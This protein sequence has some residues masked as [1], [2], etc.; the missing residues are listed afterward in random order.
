MDRPDH[1][2]PPALGEGHGAEQALRRVIASSPGDIQAHVDLASLLTRVGRVGE[3]IDLLDQALIRLPAAVWPLSVK[4][5]VLESD[6][7]HGD[8]L[9]VHRALLARAPRAALP[10]TN[11]GRALAAAGEVPAAISAYRKSLDLEPRQGLAWWGLANLRTVRLDPE[12]VAR[13]ERALPDVTEGLNRTQLHYALGKAL[14]DQQRFG[15]SFEHYEAGNR[16]RGRFTAYSAGAL[17]EAVQQIQTIF[18]PAFLAAREGQGC[19]APG[20][21]FIVGMP[22]SGS[23]LVEQILTSHPLVEG[24]GELAELGEVVAVGESLDRID[25]ASAVALG[26]RYMAAVQRHRRTT[27]PFFT[28]KMPANW[29]HVGLIRLML[30]N[31]KII[32][33]RREPMA[34]CFSSFTTYFNRQTSFPASLADLGLYYRDYVRTMDHVDRVTPVHRVSYERLVEDLEGE[35][36][37]LLDHLGLPFAAACLRFHENPRAVQTPSAQQ[38]RRP[39]NRE[40]LDRWRNYEPWLA[41]LRFNL[42][43]SFADS[44]PEHGSLGQPADTY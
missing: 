7:R 41:P 26:E 11:Y 5:S 14:G 24:L 31:A 8:A 35:T 9:D 1:Q 42:G 23:T 21:I 37:Q 15:A 6:G 13:M 12:D 16:L 10:W 17:S 43:A 25:P 27:K 34:C 36:R 22:R 39:I 3:A 38:V 29:R 33:V 19:G 30:P 32:D 20:P 40:G 28:D 18:T 4:A 2:T 44:P